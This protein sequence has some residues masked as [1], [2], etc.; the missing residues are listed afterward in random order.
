M[1]SI[2]VETTKTKWIL[3]KK[4]KVKSSLF[5]FWWRNK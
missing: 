4:V 3:I 5:L 2:L 1:S